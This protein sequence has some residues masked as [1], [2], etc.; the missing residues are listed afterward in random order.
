[1]GLIQE[2]RAHTDER[3]QNG[4][5]PLPLTADQ[6]RELIELLQQDPVEDQDYLLT[7]FREHVSP[8][9]D[10]AAFE[11][12]VFLDRVVKGDA[13]CAVIS[14]VD[15]VNIL[16]TMLGGYNVKPLVDALSHDDDS[17]ASAAA[18]MLKKTL[19]VYESFDAVAE[20]AKSNSYAKEVMESWANAEWFEAKPAIPEKMTLTVFKVPGETNT[21]DLSPASEAFT[22][23]DIPLHALSMLR[24]KMEDPIGTIAELKKKGNP[25]AFVGDVV[26]TGSSRKSGINSVQWHIGED[27]PA[28]PNKR[29]GGVVIGGII[30]PIF[31]N[32]AEDSG[33]L[34]I[35]ADVTAM[36]TGDVV[37]LYP[38][39]GKIEKDGAVIAEF[40]LEPNTLGDEVRAGG[41]IPLIIGRTLTRQARESLGL[42]EEDIF[43][44]PEQPAD[45]GKGYTLAQK[46][47]GK[48]CGLTGVRPGMYVEPETLTVGSQDTTGAMTRDEI[49]ELAALSFGADLVMQ[50][51]CHT[52]AYPKPSDVKLHKT[53]PY[54]IMSRGGVALRPGDG[55]IHTWLN[56]MVLPDTLGTGADSH[57]RFPIG[58]SFPGGSGLVAFA[59]VTG[60]MP[61]N[62]PESVLVRFKGELQ[63]GI[64]LRD[65]V[66]AIP[67]VAIKQG[68]LTVEKKGKKNIFAGRILEI[69]GLPQL[70]VEQAFEL[71]DASAERSAA[72]CTVR[73]DQEPV[74]EYLRSNVS[75]LEQMIENGYGDPETLRRR[76]G[77]MKEW[78]ANP[79]LMEPDADAEYAAVIEIDL[80]E[81]KEPI[82][83]CPN[84]PDDVITLSEALAD[85]SRPQ[86]IDEVFVGSCM[87]NIGHF[88]ALGEVLKGK[89]QVATRLWVVPPTKMDMKKLVEEGYYSL[90]GAAGARTEI[91]GCSLCM[92]NQARVADNA[93][94]FSTSTRNFDNRLGAGAQVYLGSAE[95]AAVCA[96]LGRLPKPEEYF[97]AVSSNLSGNESQVYKYL[98]F[99]EVTN[100][101]LETLV[102]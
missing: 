5:P 86:K 53:L 83:A 20:L 46:I 6:A 73:L 54:F 90:Y 94:V 27:I 84:D 60:S 40:K 95:L 99:H 87:T 47:I 16:G 24:S 25:V 101:Q 80:K 96:L 32:T 9:V 72:A 78:L 12:A 45:T 93:V 26:G 14:E 17:V 41:R 23:S 88:R 85:D 66:N 63:E 42:G 7:L 74:I 102:D 8:G 35:Q 18:E 4:I 67:Y 61:L 34:P 68:L 76:V 79:S 22:R 82:V 57:T 49:K 44:Q 50:S 97:D 21:D 69:E 29:T 36:E 52:A 65:L 13:T 31:F 38:Y 10:D 92:G 59:G 1:M 58:I 19:L 51:F 48:A 39:E 81:I 77:K 89:G 55:V 43:K 30:A 2:Y 98:N 28:V 37:E 100:E 56:R 91:P 33:A 64:T 15:A 11:K 75:L 71:S 3:A 70:N 62:V